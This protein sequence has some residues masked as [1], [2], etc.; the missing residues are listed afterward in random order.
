VCR[1]ILTL[2]T[3]GG[4]ELCVIRQAGTPPAL[5]PAVGHVS[6]TFLVVGALGAE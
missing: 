4:V 2:N 6:E 5:T 3:H 1:E